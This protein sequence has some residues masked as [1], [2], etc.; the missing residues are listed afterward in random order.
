MT[1][2]GGDVKK[3]R[4]MKKKNKQ[5]KRSER[6]RRSRGENERK[7]YK[8]RWK[9]GK[10]QSA[11]LWVAL[12]KE[13]PNSSKNSFLIYFCFLFKNRFGT[14]TCR[15]HLERAWAGP[16]QL[17]ARTHSTKFDQGTP[18]KK[19]QS[20]DRSADGRVSA[21]EI[22]SPESPGRVTVVPLPSLVIT[23]GHWGARGNEKN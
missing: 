11:F 3:N 16:R 4:E 9:R 2:T 7:R 19:S 22:R 23:D 1:E 20:A 13:K 18:M 14:L 17:I 6:R 8:N 15:W 5:T 10:L 21:H 12:E